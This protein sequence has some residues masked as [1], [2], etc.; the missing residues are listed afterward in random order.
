MGHPWVFCSPLKPKAALNGA[1]GLWED[2]AMRRFA[3]PI[4]LTLLVLL[5]LVGLDV[6]YWVLFFFWR[7]AAQP[8]Y[9]AIWWPRVKT[10]LMEGAVVLAAW[11]ADGI[12]LL[13][14]VGKPKDRLR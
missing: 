10:L 13:R 1:P 3:Y 6:V 8:Q 7:S 12:W 11:I 5:S 14:I 4:A 2:T 9:D